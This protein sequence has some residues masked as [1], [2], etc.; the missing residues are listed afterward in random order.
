[1]CGTSSTYAGEKRYGKRQCGRPGHRWKE[2]TKGTLYVGMEWIHLDE[3][4]DQK[5]AFVKTIMNRRVQ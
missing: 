4:R 5:R 1:M 2:H 3:N